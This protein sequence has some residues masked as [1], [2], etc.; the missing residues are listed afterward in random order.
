M[1]NDL[2]E[3]FCNC[4]IT[5]IVGVNRNENSWLEVVACYDFTDTRSMYMMVLHILMDNITLR[6][7][8]CSTNKLRTALILY[9]SIIIH[10][11][12]CISCSKHYFSFV[13]YNTTQHNTTQYK[14]TQHN[15]NQHNTLPH[16]TTKHN[17]T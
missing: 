2:F 3:F 16:N 7:C 4:S 8:L 10:F 5:R 14:I 11:V 15:T 9:M 6:R 13:Q 17:T 12:D 1:F